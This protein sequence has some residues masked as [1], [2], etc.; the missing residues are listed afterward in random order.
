MNMGKKVQIILKSGEKKPI[1]KK[2]ISELCLNRVTT[3]NYEKKN[4]LIF[5]LL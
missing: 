3:N 4:M 2:P 1:T 5:E